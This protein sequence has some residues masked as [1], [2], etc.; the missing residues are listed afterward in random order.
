MKYDEV[1]V[2]FVSEVTSYTS[3]LALVANMGV[4][5]VY[6]GEDET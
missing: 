3:I 5:L 1:K 2:Y 4:R 6:S